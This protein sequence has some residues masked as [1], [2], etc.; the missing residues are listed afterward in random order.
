MYKDGDMGYK[1]KAMQGVANEI[2][3][4]ICLDVFHEVCRKV[5]NEE[6]DIETETCYG[7]IPNDKSVYDVFN[8][9]VTNYNPQ[10]FY[11]DNNCG[12]TVSSNRYAPHLEKCTGLYSRN[13]PRASR[14]RNEKPRINYDEM[15]N[16]LDSMDME[17]NQ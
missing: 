3:R 11:C 12:R 16:D 13:Q 15:Y 4:E 9:D 10:P 7:A 6:I 8:R 1:A 17:Y 5:V 14:R 2:L